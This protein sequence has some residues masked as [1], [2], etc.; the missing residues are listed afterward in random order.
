MVAPKGQAR[1]AAK[2]MTREIA[3]FPQACV[4]AD[5]RSVHPQQGLSIRPPW[6]GNGRMEKGVQA[7]GLG[8]RQAFLSA[9]PEGMVFFAI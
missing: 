7:R 8:R 2:D 3:R 6:S 4:R 1:Q 9:A 5:R